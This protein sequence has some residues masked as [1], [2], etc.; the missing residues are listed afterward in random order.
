MLK[1]IFGKKSTGV[2][3]ILCA[4]VLLLSFLGALA[5]FLRFDAFTFSELL[6]YAL[7]TLFELLLISV[8]VFVQKRYKLY[9][10]P[11]VEIGICLYSLL[12]C[13]GN[14]FYDSRS[15]V[16]VNLTPVFGGFVM[17]M[18]AFC[19]LYSA[20]DALAER[21][22]RRVSVLWVS[23]L[24]FL[25]ACAAM[26]IFVG[27]SALLARFLPQ[28][29]QLLSPLRPS[30]AAYAGGALLFCIIG[31]LT[32]FSRSGERF[33]IRSFKNA[34]KAKTSENST[35]RT[36]AANVNGDETDY[37]K[38]ARRLKLQFYGARIAYIA[39]YGLYVLQTALSAR[40]NGLEWAA[41]SLHLAGLAL[42]AALYVYEFRLFR[43]GIRNQ[44]LRKLKIAKAAVR[45]YSILLSLATVF[46]ADAAFNDLTVITS[47]GMAVFNLCSL[48]YNLF[49]SPRR[50]PATRTAAAAEPDAP[51]LPLGSEKTGSEKTACEGTGGEE[52][53]STN[54]ATEGDPPS[55]PDD[56]PAGHADEAGS[57]PPLEESTDETDNT[58]LREECAN[59]ADGVPPQTD[60]RA[61]TDKTNDTERL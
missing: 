42:T 27:L 46:A 52:T 35:F 10:P 44:R 23:V 40:E 7:F 33:R 20:A 43:L 3:Y 6:A 24:S 9:I 14:A 57:A 39:L 1:N 11:A 49:G 12:F 31:G 51:L 41:F 58:P 38:L 5:A 4:A 19:I 37:K 61:Q 18:T 15:D 50:Y 25:A 36:V 34:E 29:A 2:A 45:V 26:G 48:F 28:G 32:V 54:A 17:A 59:E 13:L 16:T 47:V 30:L 53:S 56:A 8:P 60:K 22:Q 21:R 55:A